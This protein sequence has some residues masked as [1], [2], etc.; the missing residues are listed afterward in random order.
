M[1]V[2][3]IEVQ[4]IVVTR[5]GEVLVHAHGEDGKVGFEVKSFRDASDELFHGDIQTVAREVS[6][7]GEGIDTRT[8]T[9]T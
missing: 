1:V 5:R 6:M 9:A 4:R 2:K 8:W 7:A 3:V